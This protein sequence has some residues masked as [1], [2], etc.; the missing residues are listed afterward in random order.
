MFRI[1]ILKKFHFLIIWKTT[2]LTNAIINMKYMK[3]TKDFPVS[4]KNFCHT[5]RVE[6]NYFGVAQTFIQVFW[7]GRQTSPAL[8]QVQHEQMVNLS[9]YTWQ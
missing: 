3:G 7:K 4:H 5:I 1:E 8:S 6:Q 2:L 9:Q